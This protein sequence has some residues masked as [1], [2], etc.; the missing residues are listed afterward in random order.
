MLLAENNVNS[1]VQELDA[2]LSGAAAFRLYDTYGFPL[3]LTRE[4]AESRGVAI[5][6]AGRISAAPAVTQCLPVSLPSTPP[7]PLPVRLPS[8]PPPSGTQSIALVCLFFLLYP[9]VAY[10]PEME[11]YPHINSWRQL[12]R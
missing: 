3:E 10:I 1:L 9:I 5:D 8:T 11:L 4:V 7:T 2:A 12:L 6:E